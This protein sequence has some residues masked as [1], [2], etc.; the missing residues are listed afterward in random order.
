ML[1]LEFGEL[2]ATFA[3]AVVAAVAVVLVVRFDE[4]ISV[5]ETVDT[6]YSGVF[7]P[8]ITGLDRGKEAEEE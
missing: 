5:E 1:G 8:S 7:R 2:A 4:P 3:V 6:G